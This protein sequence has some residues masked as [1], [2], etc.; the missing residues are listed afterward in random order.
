[1]EAD[2]AAKQR[3]NEESRLK[4]EAEDAFAIIGDLDS[5]LKAFQGALGLDETE[6]FEED[7]D[8]Y[9]GGYEDG[10]EDYSTTDEELDPHSRKFK[11]EGLLM[12]Y[13]IGYYMLLCS[14]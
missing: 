8:E 2:L 1:M 9:E 6:E 14:Y 10:Y 12:T 11:P 5:A 3:D 4:K 7:E 13:V